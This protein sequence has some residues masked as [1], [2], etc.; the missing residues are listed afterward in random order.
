VGLISLIVTDELD[1][2]V[3]PG[4]ESGGRV[5]LSLDE[6]V[7]DG[8]SEGILIWSWRHPERHPDNT[9]VNVETVSFPKFILIRSKTPYCSLGGSVGCYILNVINII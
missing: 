5:V 7:G 3:S 8:M 2:V 9:I 4:P 6:G 1:P